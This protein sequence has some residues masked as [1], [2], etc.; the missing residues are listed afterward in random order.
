MH[1]VLWANLRWVVLGCLSTMVGCDAPIDHFEPNRLYARRMEMESHADLNQAVVDTQA[2]LERLFGTPDQPKWPEFLAETTVSVENLRRAAGPNSSDEADVQIGLYRKHCIACHGISGDGHG[3]TAR[4]LNP[5]PRDFRLGKFKAKSTPIGTKP[6]RHDLRRVLQHGIPGTSMPSFA[7]VK[8]ED[9]EALVDYVIYLTLRGEVERDLLNRA[10]LDLDDGERL[11]DERL[12]GSSPEDFRDLWQQIENT[13]ARKA[14]GWQQAEESKNEVAGPPQ[15]YPIYGQSQLSEA[16]S[17]SVARGRGLFQGAVASCSRCHGITAMGDGLTSDFDDWTKDW[18]VQAGL[19]PNDR[20]AIEPMLELGAL[21]PRNILPRN[22][23][24]GVFRGGSRPVDLYNRIVH[25][26][27]GTPMPAAAMQPD[28]PQGLS[29]SD[30]WDLVNYLLSLPDEH[31]H[32]GD[33]KL[34]RRSPS[35]QG[36]QER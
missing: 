7:L 23:R 6:T 36:W 17:T 30:V 18:S 15:G 2:V 32:D 19:N 14:A 34:A 24:H 8:A 1:I 9:R 26:I 13:V 22:L 21:K 11:F 4:L 31:F 28:N 3:P 25:G 35:Q 16:L 29:Q 12:E 10:A 20:T 27:E 5:Y 33:D